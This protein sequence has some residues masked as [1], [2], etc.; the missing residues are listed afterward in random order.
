[1]YSLGT[2][3][4]NRDD[5]YKCLTPGESSEVFEFLFIIGCLTKTSGLE[6]RLLL[7]HWMSSV[8]AIRVLDQIRNALKAAVSIEV[9]TI[10]IGALLVFES[11]RQFLLPIARND[12]EDSDQRRSPLGQ[13]HKFLNGN[14]HTFPV[15]PFAQS[16]CALQNALG[17][18]GVDLY[19][20]LDGIFE[21]TS[22][23]EPNTDGAIHQY[24]L[25]MA[26]QKITHEDRISCMVSHMW[27]TGQE[28]NASASQ[29][30]DT[31]YSQCRHV[32]S[33][34]SKSIL[35]PDPQGDT[36]IPMERS[37]TPV[38]DAARITTE[39]LMAERSSHGPIRVLDSN[40]TPS[41]NT[42]SGS[43]DPPVSAVFSKDGSDLR[44]PD[45]R[46]W[47]SS[48]QDNVMSG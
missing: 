28:V 36:R 21:N 3:E 29:Y 35:S 42:I 24:L 12:S 37:V 13:L 39:A 41:P 19:N 10:G 7:L 43:I 18:N 27:F 25:T 8:D 44:D 9:F 14:G 20:M 26:Y 1:V 5:A 45:Q 2:K 47:T 23:P 40:G 30:V 32:N 6:S 4:E 33:P 16:I 31:H 48:L 17:R 15:E 46:A 38:I 22:M 11:Q 34:T